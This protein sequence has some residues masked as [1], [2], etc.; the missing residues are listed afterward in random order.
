MRSSYCTAWYIG[1]ILPNAAGGS[2]LLYV[3]VLAIN[4][5]NFV[6]NRK[7]NTKVSILTVHHVLCVHHLPSVSSVEACGVGGEDAEWIAS[8]FGTSADM[9][10]HV[11]IMVC[12]TT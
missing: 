9:N 2:C 10:E 5:N 1:C 12:S 3:G 6:P 4:D 11:K 7:A 8:L